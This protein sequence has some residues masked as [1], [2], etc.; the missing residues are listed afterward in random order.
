MMIRKIVIC[1][2]LLSFVAPGIC[3]AA[4]QSSEED[5][6]KQLEKKIEALLEGQKKILEELE[7]VKTEV[8]KVK[9]RVR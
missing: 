7:T 9:M 3:Y 1:L 2:L 4:N 6:I 5:S 8:Q